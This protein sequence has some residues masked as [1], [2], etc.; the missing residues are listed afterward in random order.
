M[1]DRL[2]NNSRRSRRGNVLVLTAFFM[3]VMV[4]LLALGIDI[5]Y[6]Q[7]AKV[8]LQKY[9]AGCGCKH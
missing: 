1:K 2:W 5:G 3:I 6:L 7:N 4:A 9:E 8:E